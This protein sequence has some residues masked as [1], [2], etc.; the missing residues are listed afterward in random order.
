M[1]AVFCLA[2]A[3]T[4]GAY[5]YRTMFNGGGGS[6]GTPPLIRADSTP[7]KVPAAQ[8]GEGAG[9][10]ITDRF[11]GDKAQNEK[12]VSREEQPV[13]VRPAQSRPAFPAQP[14]PNRARRA[15]QVRPVGLHRL[16]R[17]M[18]QPQAAAPVRRTSRAR[19]GRFPFVQ[20][21]LLRRPLLGTRKLRHRHRPRLP[22]LNLRRA[23]SRDRLRLRGPPPRPIRH[24]RRAD[25]YR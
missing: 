19:S 25:R 22:R 1:I 9:K 15:A 2:V 21:R 23:P 11:G 8:S 24:L 3:G 4:A 20:I 16:E 18:P 13:D 5:A 17:P 6:M 7:N 10:Q 14:G 12:V